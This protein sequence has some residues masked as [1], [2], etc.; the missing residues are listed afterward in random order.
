MLNWVVIQNKTKENTLSPYVNESQGTYPMCCFG[1]Q[2]R[3]WV[4]LSLRMAL[5]MSCHWLC[6]V[7]SKQVLWPSV[8]KG[9]LLPSR[10]ASFLQEPRE[11]LPF[12][13][14]WHPRCLTCVGIPN[15]IRALVLLLQCLL[16]FGGLWKTSYLHSS[17]RCPLSYSVVTKVKQSYSSVSFFWDYSKKLMPVVVCVSLLRFQIK[18]SLLCLVAIIFPY[19]FDLLFN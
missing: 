10:S 4:T 19:E 5:H 17:K 18:T 14:L 1:L 12:S 13:V 8:P 3:P 11:V 6:S 7:F 16:Q 15:G 9:P 2:Y